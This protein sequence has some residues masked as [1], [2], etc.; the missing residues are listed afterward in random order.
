M[1]KTTIVP[2]KIHIICLS[3]IISCCFG[4]FPAFYN[5][6]SIGVSL[7]DF[8]PLFGIY[9]RMEVS[10]FGIKGFS[11]YQKL[12]SLH[13][14]GYLYRT[15]NGTFFISNEWGKEGNLRLLGKETPA[16]T[17]WEYRNTQGNWKSDRLIKIQPTESLSPKKIH[18]FINWT[19]F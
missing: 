14:Y 7:Q 9:K 19:S 10:K 3:Q 16:S 8:K 1:C 11:V 17:S 12:N 18:C 4:T 2:S 6:S 5:V 15:P 13:G